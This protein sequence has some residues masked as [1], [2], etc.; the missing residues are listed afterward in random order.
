MILNSDSITCIT[1]AIQA[2]FI[3][4]SACLFFIQ[5]FPYALALLFLMNIYNFLKRCNGFSGYQVRDCHPSAA[6]RVFLASGFA[7][8]FCKGFYRA[9][10]GYL[11]ICLHFFA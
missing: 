7:M 9:K 2:A 1:P 6:L 4:V 10:S 8:T 5:F 11:L 3:A